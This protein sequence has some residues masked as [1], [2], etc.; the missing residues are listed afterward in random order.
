[1]ED[2][3]SHLAE[4]YQVLHPY[5]DPKTKSILRLVSK[6]VRVAVDQR[7]DK[8]VVNEHQ[9]HK[10]GESAFQP[11]HL[12]IR[13]SHGP[14]NWAGLQLAYVLQSLQTLVITRATLSTELCQVSS[15]RTQPTVINAAPPSLR[16]TKPNR[17]ITCSQL[18]TLGN[19][20]TA[21]LAAAAAS[22][23]LP[24]GAEGLLE[25][26]HTPGAAWSAGGRP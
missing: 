19:I 4:V 12:T 7:V 5:L 11:F 26:D 1:M 10:L 15:A 8:L 22:M 2:H 17:Q 21:T 20:T 25:D 16:A 18:R 14:H 23:T 24:A 3:A 9:L 6:A 13:A